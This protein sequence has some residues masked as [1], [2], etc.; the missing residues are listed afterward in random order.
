MNKELTAGEKTWYAIIVLLMVLGCATVGWL[1]RAFF[2]EPKPAIVSEYK[3]P[4]ATNEIKFAEYKSVVNALD[5]CE[6]T[7][8]EWYENMNMCRIQLEA[9]ENRHYF[10]SHL[11]TAA[12]ANKELCVKCKEEAERE[13]L[14][15]YD[16]QSEEC[17]CIGDVGP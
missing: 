17:W 12:E 3:C 2:W 6:R 11:Q 15:C 1:S 8:A 4:E 7:Q 16:A 9:W 5:R 14:R 13:L 10:I